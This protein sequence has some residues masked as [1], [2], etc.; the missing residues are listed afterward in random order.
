MISSIP[1]VGPNGSNASAAD[2]KFLQQLP[3]SHFR[4]FKSKAALES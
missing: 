1:V 2:L 3:Q 4:N